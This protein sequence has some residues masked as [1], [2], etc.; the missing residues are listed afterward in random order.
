MP[1]N[2]FR[3]ITLGR[4][5]L[6][7]PPGHAGVEAFSKQRRNLAVLAVLALSPRPVP[8]DTLMEMFWGDRDEQRARH[9]LSEA[10]SQLRRLLGPDAIAVRE[11]EV[12]LAPTAPVEVDALELAAAAERGDT[13]R[14]LELYGGPFLDAVYVGGSI[15]FEEWVERER[16]RLERSFVA[17]C[18][19]HC[20]ELAAAGDWE[21]SAAAAR[22]GRRRTWQG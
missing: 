17:A 5:N 20:R 10:L 13:A 18:E 14:V 21:A 2:N 7:G 19:R 9:S 22:G 15:A 6:C 11:A 12:S 3:L 4:L 8:R 1:H 16:R